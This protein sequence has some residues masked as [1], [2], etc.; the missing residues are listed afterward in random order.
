VEYNGE[1]VSDLLEVLEA[2][3]NGVQGLV[4][5]PG[6]LAYLALLLCMPWLRW[7][8]LATNPPL[9]DGIARWNTY[10]ND[11]GQEGFVIP[12]FM[13]SHLLPNIEER[14]EAGPYAFSYN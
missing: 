7:W 4:R 5:N 2:A 9:F 3:A 12:P 13:L 14:L 8:D 6:T 10:E 11:H 1:T